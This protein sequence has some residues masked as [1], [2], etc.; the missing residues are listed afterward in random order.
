M[1]S[2]KYGRDQAEDGRDARTVTPGTDSGPVAG[3]SNAATAET[4]VDPGRPRNAS[5]Q[6]GFDYSQDLATSRYNVQVRI[7]PNGETIIDEESLFV[8]RNEEENTENYTHVEESDTTKFVNSGTYGKKFR[9]SRWSAE[10]TE[11]F[12]T[13]NPVAPCTPVGELTDLRHSPNSAK[14]MSLFLTCCLV[15]TENHARTSSRR[16]TKRTLA[17]SRIA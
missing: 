7:G 2:K 6:D 14:I 8:D 13:V 3:P 9:G 12:Y 15:A 1:E 17:E 10:E 5:H 4:N 16:R 11:R